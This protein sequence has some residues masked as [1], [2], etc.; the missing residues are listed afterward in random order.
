MELKSMS[1][2]EFGGELPGDEGGAGGVQV[3]RI[4]HHCGRGEGRWVEATVE[5]DQAIVEMFPN[6][7]NAAVAV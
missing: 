2:R 4:A 7:F 5:E 3:A 1:A 6:V